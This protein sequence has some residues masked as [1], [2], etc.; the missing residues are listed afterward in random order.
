MASN[1]NPKHLPGH[2]A[3]KQRSQPQ[4]RKK[5]R[6]PKPRAQGVGRLP[7]ITFNSS[8]KPSISVRKGAGMSPYYSQLARQFMCP[9]SCDQSSLVLSPS[10]VPN[11]VCVRHFHKSIDVSQATQANGFTAVMLPDVFM[12]GY[13]TSGSAIL[14]PSGGLGNVAMTGKIYGAN[15]LVTSGVIQV[16]DSGTASAVVTAVPIVDGAATSYYA[17]QITPG[18]AVQVTLNS[19]NTSKTNHVTPTI[20]YY[21]L[22]TAGAGAW[23][24]LAVATLAENEFALSAPNLPLNASYLGFST[25]NTSD[26]AVEFEIKISCLA[27]QVVCNP[28][29]SIGPGFSKYIIDNNITYGRVLSMSLLATNT[30][31]QLANGGNINAAR[32][33]NNFDPIK[34]VESQISSL[35]SN[36]RFQAAADHGAYVTWLPGQLD[37]YSIDNLSAKRMQLN[38]AEYILIKVDSWSAGASFKLQF[39]WIVEFYTPS[40]SFE[41]ELPPPWTNSWAILFYLMQ[42]HDAACCNPDHESSWSDYLKSATDKVKGLYN[43]Y[44]KHEAAI[45]SV[46]L[47]AIELLA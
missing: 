9:N 7:K 21:T 47:G 10:F 22:T 23:V 3:A 5:A 35:P 24:S 12:P 29:A 36:R 45:D 46:A 28:A 4:Q 18:A 2:Q 39:D 20:T 38:D 37:E 15:N 27:T 8:A 31:A 25:T 1:S 44:K 32:V 26:K 40:Q 42:A 11:S 14:V 17:I 41:K 33:P 34:N 43:F 30:S 19:K 16:S 6:P 13:V